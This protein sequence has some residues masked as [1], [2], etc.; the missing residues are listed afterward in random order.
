MLDN[1]C[2]GICVPDELP[3]E[4]I[5]AASRPYLGRFISEPS[6]WT[7]LAHYQNY[8]AGYNSPDL[9][10]DDPWQFKNFF[11]TDSHH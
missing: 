9:D 7:P 1:P 5:L 8:F 10:L 4:R 11:I 3:Y 6:D 2:R